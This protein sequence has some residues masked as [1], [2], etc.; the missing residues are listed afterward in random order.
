VKVWKNHIDWSCERQARGVKLVEQ[1]ARLILRGRHVGPYLYGDGRTLRD[2]AGRKGKGGAS[3]SNDATSRTDS[4]G[5]RSLTCTRP[6][7]RPVGGTDLEPSAA[8]RARAC[9]RSAGC[10]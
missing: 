2:R 3:G 8:A 5:P 4:V 10:A 9:E 1:G 7:A 6:E